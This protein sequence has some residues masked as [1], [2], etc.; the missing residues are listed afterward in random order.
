ML[1]VP[2][3][4]AFRRILGA[5]LFLALLDFE[6]AL[7]DRR[8]IELVLNSFIVPARRLNQK[9]KFDE[10]IDSL[11][12]VR[13]I[14]VD[15]RRHGGKADVAG[16]FVNVLA[17]ERP[18]PPHDIG[19][20][21]RQTELEHPWRLDDRDLLADHILHHVGDTG[22]FIRCPAKYLAV[23]LTIGHGG[24]CDGLIREIGRRPHSRRVC[25]TGR[26]LSVSRG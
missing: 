25:G 5:L 22:R 21:S 10:L 19:V 12:D 14:R 2:L 6:S 18:N 11:L 3:S 24:I 4:F 1:C 17:L 23:T 20:K 15:V 9:T 7:S 8:H 13:P 26:V 16:G